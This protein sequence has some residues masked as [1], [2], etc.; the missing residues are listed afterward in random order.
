MFRFLS[1]ST[2][3]LFSLICNAQKQELT[4]DKAILGGRDLAPSSWSNIQWAKNENI[5]YYSKKGAFIYKYDPAKNKTDSIAFVSQVNPK[6]K[7]L[8]SEEL[9]TVTSFMLNDN[10]QISFKSGGKNVL[11]DMKSGAL[12]FD[13]NA[14]EKGANV[15]SNDVS[16]QYAYTQDQA[17]WIQTKD[18]KQTKSS[19][20]M[21]PLSMANQ[22]TVRNLA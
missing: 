15:E 21:I 9:K 6:L 22:Y 11:M 19:K 18:G 14:P 20:A 10:N 1:I 8:S 12:K 2:F 5:L 17:L 4:L 3:L 13:V 7:E 16:G